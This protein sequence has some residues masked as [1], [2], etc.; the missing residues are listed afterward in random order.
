MGG[1]MNKAFYLAAICLL[2]TSCE[3]AKD[4][5]LVDRYDAVL[6]CVRNHVETQLTSKKETPDEVRELVY[7]GIRKC[8]TQVV[9]YVDGIIDQTLFDLR[10][11]YV[12]DEGRANVRSNVLVTTSLILQ[13][14]YNDQ[15][16]KS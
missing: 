6:S 14:Q 2:L 10:W 1:I 7:A 11:I 3:T 4:V 8:N 16:A 15:E 12:S 13:K 9:F 5:S